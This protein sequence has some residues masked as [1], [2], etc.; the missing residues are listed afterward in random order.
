MNTE[1]VRMGVP[2]H[3]RGIV[4]QLLCN[5]YNSPLKAKYA[6]YLKMHSTCERVIRRDIARTYPEHEF[7]KEKDGPGQETLF[8]VM[9]AYS[10]HDKEVGYCQGSAFIVGLLLMQMP[11]EEA[12]S[13]LV[14][15]MQD[16]RLRELFKPSMAE[17][18]V[19]M[20]Q[21]E[22]LVQELLPDL[23]QHFMTQS[24]HTSMYASSWFLTLFATCLPL[25]LACRVMDVFISEGME[26]VFRIGIA[27]LQLN[28]DMLIHMD[29]EQM[30]R[31]LQKEAPKLHA[32]EPDLLI[33]TA[34][35]V[36]INPKKMKKLEKEYL[37]IKTKENEDQIEMRRLRTE[38]NLLKQK[39]D[40]LEKENEAIADKLIQGQ[41]LRAQEAEDYYSVKKE[42]DEVLGQ[43]RELKKS[44]EGAQTVISEL[45]NKTMERI[46]KAQTRVK[47]L[48][49]RAKSGANSTV[50]DKEAEAI[51]VALQEELIAVRLREAETTESLKELTEKI[52]DL[53]E[54]NRRAKE[55]PNHSVE[56][57]QDE[58]I[59]V[60]LREAEAN[61]ALKELKQKV[62]DLEGQWQKQLQRA[63]SNRKQG[64]AKPTIQT[65]TEELM[66]V[67]LREAEAVAE[68]KEVR[69]RVMEL[70]TQN[71]MTSNQM[72]RIEEE[73][74]QL[75][76]E[77][78]TSAKQKEDLQNS[79]RANEVNF[80]SKGLGQKN[81]PRDRDPRFIRQ[82]AIYIV[83]PSRSLNLIR[84]SFFLAPKKPNPWRPIL[85]LKPLNK[86]YFA[87][88]RF[89][90]ETLASIIPTLVEGMWAISIDLKDAYLHVPIHPLYQRFLA[91][92]YRGVVYTFRALPFGLATAPRVFTRGLTLGNSED[93]VSR[94]T[95]FSQEEQ[96]NLRLRETETKATVLEL[97]QRIAGL[98][99][100]NQE[101]LTKTTLSDSEASQNVQEMQNKIQELHRE[102]SHLKGTMK[103]PAGEA[104][105]ISKEDEDNQEEPQGIDLSVLDSDD[106][107]DKS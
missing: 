65:L 15:L 12:F 58:L 99:I 84:S 79:Q 30:L 31:L 56:A 1:L 8:N 77:L 41:L 67:R 35:Q 45:R 24:F 57:M 23:F 16:Y 47:D 63:S 100:K 82:Q 7:F 3:F 38:N 44:Y 98:E 14:K 25:P 102:V 89:R 21:F 53:E 40:I 76:T 17:L 101:L 103:E 11:E 85:N 62:N 90:M 68:L 91:F 52:Q 87:T 71:Q 78:E 18:G 33:Q 64:A 59:A 13:V 107:L 94:D 19:C 72:R 105:M 5:A 93:Q 32:E 42:L 27:T 73:R 6:E 60:K 10:L 2:H 51:I 66:S 70:Q 97:K 28:Y 96:I 86:L 83:H 106:D 104:E 95:E 55:D 81:S 39:L 43:N 75:K 36:K 4:W 49:R 34:F 46:Q 69:Q 26:V 22:C 50:L 80:S 29:L 54:A 74:L 61:S 20:F 92:R 9:K 88:K 37:V 48:V